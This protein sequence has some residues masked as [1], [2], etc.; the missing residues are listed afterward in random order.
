MRRIAVIAVSID[1]QDRPILSGAILSRAV[2]VRRECTMAG[3]GWG[4]DRGSRE[5]NHMIRRVVRSALDG[6]TVRIPGS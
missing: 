5:H 2:D 1:R 4:Q 6:V 3:R